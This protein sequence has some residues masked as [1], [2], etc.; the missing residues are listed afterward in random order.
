[1]KLS[2]AEFDAVARRPPSAGGSAVEHVPR[3]AVP[4]AERLLPHHAVAAVGAA[5]STCPSR[6]SAVSSAA[7]CCRTCSSRR[8]AARPARLSSRSP[9]PCYLRTRFLTGPVSAC[10]VTA[11]AVR[12]SAARSPYW[13]LAVGVRAR[14]LLLYGAAPLV[15]VAR[16]AATLCNARTGRLDSMFHLGVFPAT[17]GARRRTVAQQLVVSLSRP[18]A[19][20]GQ[21]SRLVAS[22]SIRRPSRVSRVLR[23]Y[24]RR[25]LRGGCYSATRIAH[26]PAGVGV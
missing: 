16:G 4:W 3:W 7:D 17:S 13:V 2:A 18:T 19:D 25:F 10:C 24:R 20:R 21:S 12:G 26:T 11:V 8:T 14:Q 6:S 23:Q 9:A 1:M 5:L 15:C 22:L